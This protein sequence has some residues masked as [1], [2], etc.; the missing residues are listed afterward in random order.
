LWNHGICA[1]P[2]Q[3]RRR[4]EVGRSR[5]TQGT[6]GHTAHAGVPRRGERLRLR[7]TFARA[8]PS[9]MSYTTGVTMSARTAMKPV[10][11]QSQKE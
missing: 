4:G 1:A 2:R 5:G 3:G 6:L 10:L 7:R 9:R 11:T 8:R